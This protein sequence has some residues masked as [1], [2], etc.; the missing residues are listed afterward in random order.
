M[1]IYIKYV[2]VYV[3]MSHHH[4]KTA[5]L[6][7]PKFCTQIHLGSDFCY[8]FMERAFD[9]MDF[10]NI[11]FFYIFFGVEGARDGIGWGG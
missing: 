7:C 11:Y 4:G 2:R 1:S 10:K 9:D 6:I 3:C 5:G 8:Y